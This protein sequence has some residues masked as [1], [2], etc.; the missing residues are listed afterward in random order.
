MSNEFESKDQRVANWR[1]NFADYSD[2]SLIEEMR[3]HIDSSERHIAA[4]QILHERKQA[5]D[6]QILEELKHN[7]A[8]MTETKVQD[9]MTKE[10]NPSILKLEPNIYGIGVNLPALWSRVKSWFTKMK[11]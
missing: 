10:V 7:R 1:R 5:L 9:A 2:S 4:E 3:N 6:N 11:P 8:S